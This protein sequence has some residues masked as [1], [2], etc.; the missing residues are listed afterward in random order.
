MIRNP[1][2]ALI[3]L[4]ACGCE[5]RQ[6]DH[7]P[8]ATLDLS[9]RCSLCFL[10]REG[11]QDDFSEANKHF[12]ISDG[13]QI[14]KL[15]EHWKFFKTDRRMSCGFGYVILG[16]EDGVLK[17]EVKV[18]APCGYAVTTDG[19]YDFSS[20]YYDCIDTS[21]ILRLTKQEEDSVSKVYFHSSK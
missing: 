19:W 2:L 11:D 13:A 16:I 3:Y 10:A 20:D 4:L 5:P 8:F 12:C 1:A 7:R 21:V 15:R 17:E 9:K 18:N 6:P 14:S